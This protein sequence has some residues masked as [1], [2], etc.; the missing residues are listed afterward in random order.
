MQEV[1]EGGQVGCTGQSLGVA[2]HQLHLYL[3]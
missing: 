3:Q 2:A 1:K